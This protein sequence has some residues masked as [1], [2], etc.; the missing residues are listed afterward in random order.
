MF[1]LY[2][3]S[4]DLQESTI[5]NHFD[6]TKPLSSQTDDLSKEQG[7]SLSPSNLSITLSNN[8]DDEDEKTNTNQEEFLDSNDED[9]L[10]ADD[11]IY[12]ISIDNVPHFYE[13]SLSNAKKRM[14]DIA[15]NI[16]KT[17]NET[18]FGNDNFI[19]SRNVYQ[20]Q[21]VCPYKFLI[22]FCYGKIL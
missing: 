7:I 5:E 6:D 4:N 20:V 12:I 19:L 22:G 14:W 3:N 10:T 16:L 2:K 15:T 13:E 11:K 18:E 21:I 9:E 1:T 17:S 8:N